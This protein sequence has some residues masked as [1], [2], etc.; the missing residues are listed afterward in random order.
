M[1]R[2]SVC[3]GG[4]CGTRCLLPESPTQRYLC[5]GL[6]ETLTSIAFRLVGGALAGL[7]RG[8]ALAFQVG[9]ETLEVSMKPLRSLVPW[10]DLSSRGEAKACDLEDQGLTQCG[11]WANLALPVFVN[12]V[13][14]EQPYLWLFSRQSPVI[15]TQTNWPA[16]P[17]ILIL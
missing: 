16:E 11:A 9:S 5:P 2:R 8:A 10:W 4:A 15:A 12:K 17:K 3:E 14:L 6:R 7:G 13:L 1:T